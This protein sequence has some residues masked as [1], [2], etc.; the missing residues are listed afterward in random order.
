MPPTS[1]VLPTCTTTY[2]SS[3]HSKSVH[4]NRSLDQWHRD[5]MEEG[6]E[7]LLQDFQQFFP[8]TG[9]N[10]AGGQ[11]LSD[12]TCE[13]LG[14][15]DRNQITFISYFTNWLGVLTTIVPGTYDLIFPQ[16]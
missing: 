4:T 16:L 9:F 1:A 3:S 14:N 15:C 12:I 8:N 10:G 2:V 7:G 11:I 6:G 13:P 5:K